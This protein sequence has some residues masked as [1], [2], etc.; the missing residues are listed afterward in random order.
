MSDNSRKFESY[1]Q[2]VETKKLEIKTLET[3]I[4]NIQL[5]EKRYQK[6]QSEVADERKRLTG[7]VEVMRNLRKAL[8]N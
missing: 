5:T 2:Q 8:E 7:Q 1:Q 3:E 4:E 6:V